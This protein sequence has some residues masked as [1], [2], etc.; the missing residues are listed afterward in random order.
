MTYTIENSGQIQFITFDALKNIPFIRHGFSTKIGGVSQGVYDS[1][2]LGLKTGDCAFDVRQNIKLFTVGVGLNYENLVI[3]DQVHGDVIKIVLEADKGKGYFKERDYSSV[4]GLI[5]NIPGIPLLTI[6]ADCVP[7]Y[8]VDT[9]KKVIAVSHAGW[10]GT[11]L[12][13]GKKTVEMM[14]RHYDS[15]PKDIIALIGPSIGKCCY[16]VDQSVINEFE[17][18]FENVS[19]FTIPKKDG[20]YMLDL[21]T[22][23]KIVL[24]EAGLWDKNIRISNLCTSCHSDLFYSYRKENGVT[25]RMGAIIQLI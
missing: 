18:S 13:I 17:N 19:S 8:F 6:F 16:E 9:T 23:N 21:W 7:L 24:L 5:T 2:N 15:D 25:G 1:L 14:V 11:R 3:S 12:K 22:A 20:K 10:K 4:D